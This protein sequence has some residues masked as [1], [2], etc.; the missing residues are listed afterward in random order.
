MLLGIVWWA[1]FGLVAS[2]HAQSSAAAREWMPLRVGVE[3]EYRAHWDYSFQATG[4]PPVRRF[5]LGWVRER[6]I[7]RGPASPHAGGRIF[8]VRRETEEKAMEGGAVRRDAT[9]Q[10]LASGRR[11]AVRY[12]VREQSPLKD[13]WPEFRDEPVRFLPASPEVGREWDA[14]VLHDEGMRIDL[15]GTILAIED[16]TLTDRV[17]RGCLHVR[18]VGVPKGSRKPKDRLLRIESGRF[19]YDFWLARK[20][21]TTRS[22]VRTDLALVAEDGAKLLSSGVTTLYL[23]PS[24]GAP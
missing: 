9:D 15:R 22:V 2:A 17:Y 5:A 8:R 18:L 7:E 4:S 24:E 1:V 20:L 12:E 3:R 19:E 23:S 13:G 16:V 6:V 11:G 21:G 14:G 10:F